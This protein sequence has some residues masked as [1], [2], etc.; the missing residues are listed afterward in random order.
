MS[1]FIL[2]IHSYI[3][4]ILIAVQNTEPMTKLLHLLNYNFY[5]WIHLSYLQRPPKACSYPGFVLLSYV[6]LVIN[7][8]ALFLKVKLHPV[9]QT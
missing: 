9:V 3:L 6:S 5:L 2:L 1:L 7:L 8:V 4:Y